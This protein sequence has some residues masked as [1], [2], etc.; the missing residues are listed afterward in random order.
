MDSVKL[1]LIGAPGSG[2]G[3]LAQKLA[4][5]YDIPHISTGD[6][7]RDHIA[8]ETPVGLQAK[9]VLARGELVSDEL[10]MQLVK[11]TLD[12]PKM[13]KGYILDGFPRTLAQA[14][15]FVQN[16]NVNHYIIFDISQETV[17]ER[18]SGRRIH[19]ASGR[20]YHTKFSPPK[21]EGKDDETGEE[22]M[23]REDDKPE[24]VRNRLKVYEE[25]TFPIIAYIEKNADNVAHI[26]AELTETEILSATEKII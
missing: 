10:I 24:R 2:K 4:K 14:T 5:K 1:V 23:Q 13:E 22:L 9:D 11:A 25:L 6:I 17:I 20:I 18:I 7:I 8:Q 16:F 15:W 26:N 12:S 19:P 3:T 21:V